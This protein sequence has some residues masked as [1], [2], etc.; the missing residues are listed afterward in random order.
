MKHVGFRLFIDF[1][2]VLRQMAVESDDP[3]GCKLNALN[4]MQ[5]LSELTWQMPAF[6]CTLSSILESEFGLLLEEFMHKQTHRVTPL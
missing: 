5:Y 4:D 6:I 3:I 2:H 1:G